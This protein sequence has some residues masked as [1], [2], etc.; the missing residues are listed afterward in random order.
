MRL[1]EVLELLHQF[2]IHVTR[3][4]RMGNDKGYRVECSAGEVVQVYD[5]GAVVPQG[6]N[7][8]RVRAA[9]RLEH[10]VLAPAAAPAAIGPTRLGT[11][12]APP[13][14]SAQN[15][16][17]V[18]GHDKEARRDL[19]LML[20]RWGLNPVILDQL[21]SKGDTI[22]EKLENS[23]LDDIHFA[24]VLATPDDVGASISNPEKLRRR[25]RQNV[26]L[27][28]GMLLAKLKRRHIAILVN[29]LIDMERPSDIDG[30]LY[31]PY[32]HSVEDAAR[33]LAKEMNAAGV[34][35]DWASL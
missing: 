23:T 14:A 4:V 30:L 13:L 7:Q 28:L 11:A 2:G 16:F 3:Q 8:D 32:Q 27:E 9:L 15:V 26:V 6:A 25:A 24:V 34:K 31:I 33:S 19:E 10:D 5:S 18:Y 21:P 22:I 20:R 17:V 1:E 29:T 35:I 12:S